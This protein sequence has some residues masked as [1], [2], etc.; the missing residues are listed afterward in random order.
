VLG[1]RRRG[2]LARLLLD[3]DCPCVRMLRYS[4]MSL[5]CQPDPGQSGRPGTLVLA[6]TMWLAPKP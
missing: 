1:P 5:T 6:V 4:M 3:R 2:T